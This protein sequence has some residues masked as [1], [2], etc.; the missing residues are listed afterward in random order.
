MQNQ[1]R[2]LMTSESSMSF[3]LNGRVRDIF[4]APPFKDAAA[5]H[6]H[7]AKQEKKNGR[8]R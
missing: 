5:M 6:S 4:W 7:N 2:N 8:A 3:S 1:V